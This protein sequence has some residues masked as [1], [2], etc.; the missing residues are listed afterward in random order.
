MPED[1]LFSVSPYPLRIIEP[2][3]SHWAVEASQYCRNEGQ[4]C[5]RN[6]ELPTVRERGLSRAGGIGE[7]LAG[8]LLSS[9]VAVCLLNR[10]D[11]LR[12]GRLNAQFA[13]ALQDPRFPGPG[14]RLHLSGE[15]PSRNR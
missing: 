7:S 11:T 12:R 6:R 15:R 5:E 9:A 13:P 3:A 2:V 10:C 4:R 8:R 1:L 14:V